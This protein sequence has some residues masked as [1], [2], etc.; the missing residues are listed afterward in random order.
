MA[1]IAGSI[2]G[3]TEACAR[4]RY[5]FHSLVRKTVENCVKISRSV[6]ETLKTVVFENHADGTLTIS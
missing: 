1:A 2:A 5:P 4:V 3:A 6:F